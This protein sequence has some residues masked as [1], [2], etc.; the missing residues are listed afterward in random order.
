M[1]SRKYLDDYSKI[2]FKSLSTYSD[3][4]ILRISNSMTSNE[5]LLIMEDLMMDNPTEQEVGR[6]F[7]KKLNKQM[8][9]NI[10]KCETLSG[11]EQRYQAIL[12]ITDIIKSV[13]DDEEARSELEKAF[14]K[15]C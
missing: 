12:K 8:T 10:I 5:T 13:A 3:D 6:K 15:Y 14:P 11:Q 1:I 9:L 4:T 7:S 2:I